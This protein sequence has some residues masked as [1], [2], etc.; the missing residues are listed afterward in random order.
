M[1]M[2]L[3]ATVI[4]ALTMTLHA[5]VNIKGNV[6]FKG[7]I[8][9]TNAGGGFFASLVQKWVDGEELTCGW[10]SYPSCYVGSPGLSLNLSATVYTL[11]LTSGGGSWSPSAP[12]SLGTSRYT[13]TGAGWQNAYTDLEACRTSNHYIFK[14]I[15]PVLSSDN[16]ASCTTLMTYCTSTG[17][18]VPQTAS[19]LANTPIITLSA[20]DSSLVALNEPVGAGGIQDN[21]TWATAP[22]LSNPDMT[23][24]N[25]W[26]MNGPTNG[27]GTG[28]CATTG[29]ICGLTTVSVNTTTLAAITLSASPQQVNLANGYVSPTM[30]P[31]TTSSN[32]GCSSGFVSVDTAGSQEC[33]QPV[34]GVNSNGIYAVFTK[35]HSSGVVLTYTPDD[36]TS[37]S[38][39]GSVS[40]SFALVNGTCTNISNYNYASLMPRLEC[41]ALNC[42]PFQLCNLGAPTCSGGSLSA[43]DHWYFSDFIVGLPVGSMSGSNIIYTGSSGAPTAT[44]QFC[45]DI[46]FRR[47]AVVGDWTSLY[48]GANAIANAFVVSGCQYSSVEGSQVSQALR[49]GGEGHSYLGQ[50]ITLKIDNN[51]FEG[52]SVCIFDGGFSSPLGILTFVPFTNVEERRNRCTYPYSWLGNAT[53]PAGNPNQGGVG[54]LRKNCNELKE[55]QFVLID[56]NLCE[57]IDKSGGQNGQILTFT[58]RQNSGGGL[59][60][61]YV[62][63]LYDVTYSNNV[64]RGACNGPQIDARSGSQSNGGGVSWPIQRVSWINDLFYSITNTNVNCNTQSWGFYIGSS[65]QTWNSTISV[66]GG[67]ATVVGFAS[68][69]GGVQVIEAYNASGSSTEYVT[70]GN[71]LADNATVCGSA[72]YDTKG[73]MS[74]GSAVLTASDA[75]FTSGMVGLS[76]SVSG[77]GSGGSTLITTVASYTSTSSITLSAANASGGNVT[78][79]N[80]L[81]TGEYLFTNGFSGS[82]NTGNNSSTSGFQCISANSNIST[83]GAMAST[84]SGVLTASNA[85]FDSG[86]VGAGITATG[87]GNASGLLTSTIASYQSTTQVTLANDAKTVCSG[88]TLTITTITVTNASGVAETPA[89]AFA[90][91]ILANTTPSNNATMGYQ[92]VNMPSGTA[93]QLT[94]CSN[95]LFNVP[96]HTI[97]SHTV[98]IGIGPTIST[99]N[100]PWNGTYSASNTTITYPWGTS[101]SVTDGSCVLSNV[102][103]GPYNMLIQNVTMITDATHTIGQGASLSQGPNFAYQN[104]YLDTI[105]LSGSGAS[106]AWY[107]GNSGVTEG[108]LTEQWATD[109]TSLTA[110]YLLWPGRTNTNYTEYGNNP[111]YGDPSCTGAGCTPPLTM[112][113]PTTSCAIGFVYSCSGAIPLNLPDYHGYAVTSG[114]YNG[115]GVTITGSNSID[116]AQTRSQYTC[117]TPCGTPGPFPY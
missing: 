116:N 5:Q 95:A 114:T 53:V 23:G 82:Y 84:S 56:G 107:S 115:L 8:V 48:T 24:K 29:V 18:L 63:G 94:G 109:Y 51:W 15:V 46:H 20:S 45:T 60:L 27:N 90:N 103:G 74:T 2:R 12:C 25:M 41:T 117:L 87:C 83:V 37:C 78:N 101:G 57:L 92:A 70:T 19:S 6:N 98:P 32:N 33:V 73:A 50:G 79:A 89:S 11:T 47:M 106:S 49:P 58:A 17:I 71:A 26:Y 102:M 16:N 9:F 61:N 72:F 28:G 69:D 104:A 108:T 97:S 38:G 31:S 14:L 68:I 81:T 100:L 105:F 54:I 43:P 93:A 96:T 35:N 91:P 67:Q 88:S 85:P 112:Y 21:T 44:S 65:S 59:G 42:T 1:K 62:S 7:N 77:A 99:G 30:L 4:I 39:T 66:A 34:Q 10:G 55:G 3:L 80:V 75:P 64:W 86:M 76:I 40:G 36:G 113:F 22:G 52:E 110:A 111:H 13:N